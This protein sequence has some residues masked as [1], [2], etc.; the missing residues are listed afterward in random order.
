M[1][2]ATLE[3]NLPEDEEDYNNAINGHKYITALREV[4]RQLRSLSKHQNLRD[5]PIDRVRK[6][7]ADE[8]MNYN[9]VLWD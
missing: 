2:K 5:I 3:F 1:T 6:L 4:D 7:I 9:L 8:L